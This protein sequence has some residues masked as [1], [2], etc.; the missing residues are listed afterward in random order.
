M[1]KWVVKGSYDTGVD[2]VSA[3]LRNRGVGN[4]EKKEFLNPPPLAE[5][6][7]RMPADFKES[8][9][10]AREEVLN[11][12]GQDQPIIIHGDYDADGICATAILYKTLNQVLN[13]QKVAYFIPNRFDHGY[14]LSAESVKEMSDLVKKLFGKEGGLIITADCGITA[15]DAVVQSAREAGFRL[16]I[17]DH[18]QKKASEPQA[19]VL[20]WNDSMVGAG[21]ALI[22][23]I[24]LG[25]R[26]E[27]LASL[28]GIATVTDLAPL[29]GFNRALVKKSLEIL[30]TNPPLGIKILLNASSR[31]NGEISVYDLGYVIGPRLNATGRLDS[32]YDSLKLLLEDDEAEAAQLAQKL[33]ATNLERQD[34]T[35]KMFDLAGTCC[36]ENTE[37]SVVIV[38]SAE[39]HE[40]VVGL[41]AGKLAQKYYK[42]AIVVS[43]NGDMAKGSARS[44]L[45]VDIIKMLRHFE[46]RFT[47]LGGHP[48][49][50]GFS[51]KK[52]SLE[53]FTSDFIKHAQEV[54]SP[55]FLVPQLFVDLEIPLSL[56]NVDLLKEVDRTKP[57]GIGNPE[58]LFLSRNIGVA[59][60]NFV[61]KDSSHL[62][63]RL[64]DGQ[65]TYKAI[66]FDARN[67]GVL[68]FDL[69]TKLDVVY[70]AALKEFN[71]KTSVDLIVKD[72]MLSE[73]V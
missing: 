17:T 38:S 3:L 12:V 52:E 23:S 28:A 69:G 63:L 51:L 36:H 57:Y 32:A 8:L 68:G 35:Q 50:A 54:I 55:D 7:K 34:M 41:V 67:L 27:Q 53:Q 30:T 40:G 46:D 9:K 26:D 71:G 2:V 4:D 20:L 72:F 10:K 6:L 48:M 19:D 33:N 44:V 31:N 29:K 24:V 18:H 60:S 61:G 66:L 42:P 62:S 11:A 45:G 16:I 13:Y 25:L 1:K 73:N 5:Y 15:E 64:F 37:K 39:F 49:A 21:V 65:N 70:T 43:I 58:P 59:G 56:I 14:G 47:G 22:L